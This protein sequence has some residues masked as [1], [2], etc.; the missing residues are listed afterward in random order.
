MAQQPL[1]YP[2]AQPTI[3]EA[4][5]ESKNS[6]VV[7]VHSQLSQARYTHHL[8][9]PPQADCMT[10][11]KE[12]SKSESRASFAM[13]DVLGHMQGLRGTPS[14]LWPNRLE[15]EASRLSVLALLF[16][17]AA[18]PKNHILNKDENLL[19]SACSSLQGTSRSPVKDLLVFW[20]PVV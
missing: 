19:K 20:P 8:K 9:L 5:V 6:A 4:P 2:P 15:Q 11:R 16:S 7:P 17:Y 13:I 10:S 3:W 18:L 14:L 12:N 1:P